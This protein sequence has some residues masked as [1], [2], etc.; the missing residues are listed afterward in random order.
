VLPA[1]RP[2][3]AA[4]PQ[5]LRN[6]GMRDRHWEQLSGQLRFK[7]HP[8]K[9]F[10]MAQAEQLGLLNHLE[11]ITKVADVAGKEYSIEQVCVGGGGTCRMHAHAHACTQHA[12]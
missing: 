5:A 9:H 7:L 11:V 8:D 4:L 10:T 6:P 2:A 12:P 3:L 1:T